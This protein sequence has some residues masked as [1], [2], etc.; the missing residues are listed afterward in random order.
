MVTIGPPPPP[1]APPGDHKARTP[2]EAGGGPG[3]AKSNRTPKI[4]KNVCAR[5]FVENG[6]KQA[7]LGNALRYV[8][9]T[10]GKRKWLSSRPCLASLPNAFLHAILAKPFSLM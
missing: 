1:P 8:Q 4:N 3:A 7:L 6:T 5:H 9:T 10:G 2:G